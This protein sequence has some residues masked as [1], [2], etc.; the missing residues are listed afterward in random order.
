MEA[1]VT[2]RRIVHSGSRCSETPGRGAQTGSNAAVKGARAP[3]AAEERSH[4]LRN[5]WNE[6]EFL[7][8]SKAYQT[9]AGV[10]AIWT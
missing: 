8:F 3:V 1:H 7:Q 10:D 9:R 4:R 6:T 2:N 5:E